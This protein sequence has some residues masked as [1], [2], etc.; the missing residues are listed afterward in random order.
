VTNASRFTG[1]AFVD[2]LLDAAL[3]TSHRTPEEVL[4]SLIARE[5]IGVADLQAWLAEKPTLPE[6]AEPARITRGQ[7]FF[8]RNGLALG[9]SL[10][11]SALPNSYA[12]PDGV[13]VLDAAGSTL[14]TGPR[15]RIAET[16]RF[17]FTVAAFNRGDEHGSIDRWT[18]SA[19]GAAR[20]IRL[21]HGVVRA[22]VLHDHPDWEDKHGTPMNQFDLLGTLLAFTEL[23]RETAR[24]VEAGRRR[25]R[26]LPTP[27]VRDWE[28]NGH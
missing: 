20:R 17:L 25:I 22:V 23:G 5:D 3:T 1:D 14:L 11:C 8:A 27:L 6:W 10:F 12:V 9:T 7:E 16:A 28:R 2:G 24:L 19:L 13:A 18:E 15:R 4:R 26:G 21:F